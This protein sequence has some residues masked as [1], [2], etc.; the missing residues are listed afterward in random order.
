MGHGLVVKVRGMQWSNVLAEDGIFWIYD[1]TN[2]GTTD[3]RKTVFGFLV[4]TWVGAGGGSSGNTE[5]RDDLSFFDAAEDLT[6]SWD[7]DNYIDRSSNPKWIG[8]VGYLGYGFLE[9]PGN[10]FDGIDNDGDSKRPDSPRFK[11]ED[12]PPSPLNPNGTRRILSRTDPGPNPDFPNNKIV[13]IEIKKVYSPL[14]KVDQTI[15]ERKIVSLD[16]LFK[17]DADTVIVYSLGLPFK[18]WS[19]K[20]LVEIPNNGIDDD[21]DGLIDESFDL[22]Y[23]QIRKTADGRTIFD[24]LNPLAYKNYFTGARI[25]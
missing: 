15:Y 18:I 11:A 13:L 16:T 1:I 6:Y 8:N 24:K 20:E 17:S 4:G 9:T 21:L 25:K 2:E 12:F 5:W 3:Y 14:Y 23:R 19:G 7:A 22:H 10:P